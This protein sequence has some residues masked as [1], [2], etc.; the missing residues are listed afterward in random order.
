MRPSRERR[1][2]GTDAAG[3]LEQGVPGGADRMNAGADGLA[4]FVE[5]RRHCG[6]AHRGQDQSDA[7]VAFGTDRP[8][9]VDRLVAQLAHT[10]PPLGLSTMIISRFSAPRSALHALACLCPHRKGSW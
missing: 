1:A 8:E 4:E 7:S 6:G 2:E 9:E 10:R 5:L 3:F